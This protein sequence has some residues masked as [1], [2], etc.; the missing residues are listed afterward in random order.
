MTFGMR[1]AA[2]LAQARPELQSFHLVLDALAYLQVVA[3]AYKTQVLVVIQ[4]SKEMI[5]LFSHDETTPDP[6]HALRQALAQRGLESLDLTP[7]FWQWT[8][9]G[10][11]LFFTAKRYPNA[12]G[13]ALI[14]PEAVRH[15]G[16]VAQGTQ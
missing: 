2:I 1:L 6:S 7:M 11:Q 16:T 12:Q 4:P 14:A 9:T 8:S 13:Q 10:E 3:R 15:L 5:S